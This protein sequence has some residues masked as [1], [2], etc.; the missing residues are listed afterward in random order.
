MA[1]AAGV[2]DLEFLIDTGSEEDLLS[3][4]DKRRYY[5]R[6]EFQDAELP[7]NL[8]RANGPNRAD[9]IGKVIVPEANSKADIYLFSNSPPVVSVGKRYLDEDYGFHWPPYRKLF[10]V[11]PDGSKLQ[12][13]L[14][15]RIPDI[16]AQATHSR[17]SQR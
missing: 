6:S 4:P 10:F 1:C 7:A 12:Y 5:P 13:K 16:G 11:K 2:S 9:K 8:V 15:D 17:L 14:R 3:I